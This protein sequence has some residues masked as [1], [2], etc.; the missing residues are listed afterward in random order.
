MRFEMWDVSRKILDFRLKILDFIFLP[1]CSMLAALCFFSCNNQ[2]T[3]KPTNEQ[4]NQQ[5][6]TSNAKSPIAVPSFNK[7]SA[8]NYLLAQTNFGPRNPGSVGHKKCL[9]YLSNELSKFADTVIL[10]P[11]TH[12]GYGNEVFTMTN[13]LGRFQP[14]NPNRILLLAHWD[15]RPRADRDDNISKQNQPILG[16]ND[17]ASGVAV[18]LEIARTLKET[19]PNIGVDILFVDGEDYGE[20]GDLSR[21]LLGAKYFAKNFRFEHTP[22]FG[23]LLDMIGDAELEIKREKASMHFAPDVVELVWNTAN[24]LGIPQ[25]A[26]GEGPSLIDDHIP[27]NEVGIKCIDLID[28]NYPNETQNY[29]HTTHD[30][31]EHCSAESLEAVG[32]VLL[33]VIFR[34]QSL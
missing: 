5:T 13:I 18:L 2:Q 8:W 22:Q 3:N 4:T 34:F 24:E 33:N 20:E 21:Y 9:Q 23:I 30:T 25:F 19:K 14:N 12:V 16:A 10:Q 6:Q 31:P 27:F 28:F 32:T 29:W 15:T 26:D 7:K 11:F 1:L 17:G